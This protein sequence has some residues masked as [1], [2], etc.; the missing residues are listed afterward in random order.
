LGE[1]HSYQKPGKPFFLKKQNKTKQ[2]KTK[3]N[4]TKQNTKLQKA[5][6]Q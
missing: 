4:K 5:S 3:Q 1:R 6:V 2:N